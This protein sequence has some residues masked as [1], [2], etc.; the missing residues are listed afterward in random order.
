MAT[1]RHRPSRRA[2][3]APETDRARRVSCC[4]VTRPRVDEARSA[5]P[6]PR[7]WRRSATGTGLGPASR[8]LAAIAR[9]RSVRRAPSPRPHGLHPSGRPRA[10][11]LKRVSPASAPWA[12]A[13]RDRLARPAQVVVGDPER[14]RARVRGH[15]RRSSS[16]ADDR[17]ESRGRSG[18]TPTSCDL[19]HAA[20][21]RPRGRAARGRACLARAADGPGPCR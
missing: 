21:H 9:C 17:L 16:D 1:A 13:S 6:A 12:A 10:R 19:H 7:R 4:T 18:V 20:R 2:A 15:E 8:G 5:R 11:C 3:I 14:Q